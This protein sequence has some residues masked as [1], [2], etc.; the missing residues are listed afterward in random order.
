MDDMKGLPLGHDWL[1]LLLY[2]QVLN[3]LPVEMPKKP[4]KL[5]WTMRKL[6]LRD[7]KPFPESCDPHDVRKA[8]QYLKSL[9]YSDRPPTKV[10]QV[11]WIY[12]KRNSEAPSYPPSTIRS[13]KWCI[14]ADKKQIDSI[15]R[16]IKKVWTICNMG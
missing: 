16:E 12:A 11:C 13:G 15:W 6:S 1:R 8:S 10:N 5:S 2:Y 4:K 9:R 7:M 3:K 14:F